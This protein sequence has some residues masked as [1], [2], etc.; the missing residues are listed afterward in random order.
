MGCKGSKQPPTTPA[1]A[2][3]SLATETAVAAGGQKKPTKPGE[4]SYALFLMPS[5]DSLKQARDS[6]SVLKK[7]LDNYG[8]FYFKKCCRKLRYPLHMTVCNFAGKCDAPAPIGPHPYK[9]GSSLIDAAKIAATAAGTSPY[10]IRC[11]DKP[12]HHADHPEDLYLFKIKE[13]PSLQLMLEKLNAHSKLKGLKSS[14]KDLHVSFKADQYIS[15]HASQ[16]TTMLDK[17]HWEVCVVEI[18]HDNRRNSLQK[19]EHYPLTGPQ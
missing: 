14:A 6:S 18:P 1:D 13:S 11:W 19:N 2:K 8:E 3:Q 16:I 5:D 17:F 15:N 10:Y 12:V 4:S 7:V 9:H